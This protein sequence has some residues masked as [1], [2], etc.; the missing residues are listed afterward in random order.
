MLPAMPLPGLPVSVNVILERLNLY[1]AASNDKVLKFVP[2]EN[3]IGVCCFGPKFKMLAVVGT[4]A[5]K[6]G[7]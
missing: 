5:V 3:V 1:F 7:E 2:P 4:C 6:R